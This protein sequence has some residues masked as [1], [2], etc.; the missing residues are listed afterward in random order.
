MPNSLAVVT[1]I[2]LMGH[3]ISVILRIVHNEVRIGTYFS[4]AVIAIEL[5]IL[6]VLLIRKH[7]WLIYL[8]T[9]Y[10]LEVLGTFLWASF[11]A[12]I[13]ILNYSLPS[14][15][16]FFDW[17]SSLAFNGVWATELILM[18]LVGYLI[19]CEYEKTKK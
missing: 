5:A 18:I 17:Y 11:D 12:Y 14:T 13:S 19:V 2:H 4:M 1:I 8:F 7:K 16:S 6:G 9:I 3:L 15:H 10:S